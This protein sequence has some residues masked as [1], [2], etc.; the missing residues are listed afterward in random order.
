M[1][2][3]RLTRILTL[4]LIDPF[5]KHFKEKDSCYGVDAGGT[6]FFVACSNE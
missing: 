6:L 5:S 3:R 1:L 4:L 2:C